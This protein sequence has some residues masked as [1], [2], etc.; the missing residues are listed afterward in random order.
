[1]QLVISLSLSPSL[2]LRDTVK[3]QTAAKHSSYYF[4]TNMKGQQ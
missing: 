4:A 1:M 2:A 3:L